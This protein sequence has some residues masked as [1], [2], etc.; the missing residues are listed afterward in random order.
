[1]S[2]RMHSDPGLIQELKSYVLGFRVAELQMLLG[3][4]Q[5]NRTGKK[6]ELQHRALLLLHKGNFS[7]SIENKIREL[8]RQRNA[9]SGSNSTSEL[10]GSEISSGGGGHSHL[11]KRGESLLS[12]C[13]LPQ[14][15]TPGGPNRVAPNSSIKQHLSA[16]D[17]YSSMPRG[18]GGFDYPFNSNGSKSSISSHS[19]LSQ[20]SSLPYPLMADVKFKRLPFFDVIA[21]LLK[22]A[23]LMPSNGSRFQE[24]SFT[25]H[26][27]PQQA[28]DVSISREVIHDGRI[29]H[30][31]QIQLRLCLMETSCEQEDNLPPGMC[32]KVN[33]KICPL[34]NPLAV[35]KPGVEPKRPSRPVNITTFCR[36]SPVASNQVSITWSADYSRPYAVGI[37]L[38]KRLTANELLQRIKAKGIKN[39]E[40]TRAMIKEKL[41]QDSDSEIKTM[42]LRGSLLCPL[43]KMKI[44]IP[45][46]AMTCTHIQCF[47]ALLYLQMNEKKPTWV[48]PVCDKSALYQDLVIDGLFTDI[49]NQAPIDCTE[50]QFHEDGSWTH[51]LPKKDSIETLNENHSHKKLK[52]SQSPSPKSTPKKSKSEVEIIT[53]DSESEDEEIS[54][55]RPFSSSIEPAT[56]ILSSESSSTSD[57]LNI[58]SLPSPDSST[59]SS[60]SPNIHQS[61]DHT[62][63][64]SVNG[65]NYATALCY[66][67]SNNNSN[68]SLYDGELSRGGMSELS[69]RSGP[70]SSQRHST[71][72]APE[73]IS[74]D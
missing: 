38:V 61:S 46:R 10:Q 2:S 58:S 39:I 29:E 28:N 33:S 65:S 17:Y 5:K 48:C 57:T 21:D 69:Y 32:V 3:F 59:G 34:P 66:A 74:L 24:V 41:A 50:V 27:T 23:T 6:S 14:S 70:N 54:R 11:G 53:L 4:A 8:H 49:L 25:F 56:P 16:N 63:S 42:I 45:C 72:S 18:L 67:N 26:L 36:I 73:L 12:H 31:V 51:I 20:Q 71:D 1:M 40:Y 52:N 43:G 60:V 64:R 47:D 7:L 68:H 55:S 22:P 19:S 9:N 35:N 30:T 13:N 62:S 15:S 44:Q 37:F